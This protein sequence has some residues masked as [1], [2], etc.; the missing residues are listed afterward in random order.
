MRQEF[1]ELTCSTACIIFGL[2]YFSTNSIVFICIPV[3][4]IVIK[5]F[6]QVILAGLKVIPDFIENDKIL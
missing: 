2:I 6:Q 1:L 4:F 3:S 5:I